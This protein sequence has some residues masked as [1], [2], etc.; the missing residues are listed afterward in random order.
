VPLDISETVSDRRAT[1]VCGVVYR[2]RSFVP[3]KSCKLAESTICIVLPVFYHIWH[4]G[5][6]Q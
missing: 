1:R 4:R 2:T 3:M 5:K 6:F